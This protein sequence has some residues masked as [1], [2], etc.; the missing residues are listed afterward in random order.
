AAPEAPPA[1]ALYEIARDAGHRE[2]HVLAVRGATSQRRLGTLVTVLEDLRPSTLA[3]SPL[4]A[5]VRAG[6]TAAGAPPLRVAGPSFEAC[7]RLVVDE[8]GSVVV[9]R[10]PASF[11][12]ELDAWGEPPSSFALMGRLKKA[13]D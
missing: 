1:G 2:D 11:R 3:V 12:D 4:S 10:M 8:G 7:R 9:S 13:Y 6:W 5:T